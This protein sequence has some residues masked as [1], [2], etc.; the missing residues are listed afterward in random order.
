MGIFINE[1]ILR[2]L[3]ETV[4]LPSAA[5]FAEW[6]TTGTRQRGTRQRSLCRVSGTRQIEALGKGDLCRA[7]G[8]RQRGA[9]GKG[10]PGQTAYVVVPFAECPAVRHSAKEPP[11]PSAKHSA[12]ACHVVGLGSAR[13]TA[14]AECHLRRHSAKAYLP[15]ATDG[16]RQTV[17]FFVFFFPIFFWGLDTVNTSQLQNLGQF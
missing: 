9:L 5:S 4:T 7:P 13:A 3:R 12:K 6:Q 16:T 10:G 1:K 14:F 17:F 2:P 8:T 15:S 11:L